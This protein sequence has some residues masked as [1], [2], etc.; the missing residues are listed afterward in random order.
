MQITLTY[1]ASS[2]IF[3]PVNFRLGP[4]LQVAMPTALPSYTY[5]VMVETH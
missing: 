3:L 4:W 1:D 2:I 5:F